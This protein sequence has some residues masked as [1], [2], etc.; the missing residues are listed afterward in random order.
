M[1]EDT[2]TA[3]ELLRAAIERL[4]RE[5][6]ERGDDPWYHCTRDTRDAQLAILR[7]AEGW[8]A[9]IDSGHTP[10]EP[11][12]GHGALDLARAILAE[13]TRTEPVTVVVSAD[14]VAGIRRYMGRDV[15]LEVFVHDAIELCM[16]TASE[17]E[18]NRG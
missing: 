8:A 18:A 15:D 10:D 13:D 12:S 9:D 7:N 2:R 4:E 6:N 14:D 3:T 17:E 11:W 1:A 16:S 5:A